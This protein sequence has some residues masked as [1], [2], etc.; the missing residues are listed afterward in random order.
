MVDDDVDGPASSSSKALDEDGLISLQRNDDLDLDETSACWFCSF[1]TPLPFASF[2]A[3]G[4]LLGLV[5]EL[6]LELCRMKVG[7]LHGVPIQQKQALLKKEPIQALIW[8]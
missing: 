8:S 1:S 3:G 2:L 4:L 6:E 7:F 5:L